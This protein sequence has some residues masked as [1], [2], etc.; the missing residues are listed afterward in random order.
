[1]FCDHNLFIDKNTNTMKQKIRLTESQLHNIIRKCV[2]EVAVQGKSGK[3]YSLHGNNADDW[4]RIGLARN[5]RDGYTNKVAR[6]MQN[7]VD[8]TT[9]KEKRQ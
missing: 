1:M 7:F 4:M 3:T 8:S 2:N 6:S 9:K 5:H